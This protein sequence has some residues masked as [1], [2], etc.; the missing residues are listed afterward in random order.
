MGFFGETYH[1]PV[2]KIL[3]LVG[4]TLGPL[5]TPSVH[6]LEEGGELSVLEVE[7]S[8][9]TGMGTRCTHRVQGVCTFHALEWVCV[10]TKQFA[11]SPTFV[12]TGLV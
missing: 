12:I 9:E 4:Q 6:A 1:L 5:P 7:G 3:T 11:G 8:E 2:G 10:Y